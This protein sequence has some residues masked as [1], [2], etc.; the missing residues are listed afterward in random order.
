MAEFRAIKT[1]GALMGRKREAIRK[2]IRQ[3]DSDFT[4]KFVEIPPEQWTGKPPEGLTSVYRNNQFI[5]QVFDK[6]IF[7]PFDGKSTIK[8]MVR[9][10]TGKP[11]VQWSHLQDIKNQI[12]GREALAIQYLPPHSKLVDQANMYWFFVKE[13]VGC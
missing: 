6:D 7:D 4:N 10:N 11:I 1:K 13:T 3:A 5:V 8:V 9:H 2:A 12:F